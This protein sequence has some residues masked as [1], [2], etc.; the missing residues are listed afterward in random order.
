MWY[1]REKKS[2]KIYFDI[3]KTRERERKRERERERER[4]RERERERERKREREKT[5][6]REICGANLSRRVPGVEAHCH[7][8]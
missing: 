5:G 4:K 1:I 6:E 2:R 7:L 3:V 8:K